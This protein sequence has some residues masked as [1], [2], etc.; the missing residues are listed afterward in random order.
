[1]VPEEENHLVRQ[2]SFVY[3]RSFFANIVFAKALTQTQSS[4]TIP[5]DVPLTR[6]T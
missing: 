5:D 2:N 4:K 1:M 3:Q 6:P